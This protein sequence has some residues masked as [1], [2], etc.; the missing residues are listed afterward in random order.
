MSE[1]YVGSQERVRCELRLDRDWIVSSAR[2][3]VVC[4]DGA[5]TPLIVLRLMSSTWTRHLPSRN[6][7]GA[8]L[9][10]NLSVRECL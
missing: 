4:C 10:T 9:D 5:A 3:E 6:L 7:T 2:V 8:M 1:V